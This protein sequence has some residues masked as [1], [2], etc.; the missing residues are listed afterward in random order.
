MQKTVGA[1][2]AANVES[3]T[4]STTTALLMFWTQ[5][6]RAQFNYDSMQKAEDLFSDIEKID[7]SC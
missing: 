6:F 2:M 3:H 4:P 7:D 1:K 5:V